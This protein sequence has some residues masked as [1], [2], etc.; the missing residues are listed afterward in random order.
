MI[1]YKDS[2]NSSQLWRQLDFRVIIEPDVIS[3]ALQCL[4]KHTCL[5][6]I[7]AC[8]RETH[9]LTELCDSDTELSTACD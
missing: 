1:A 7:S 6:D 3:A 8:A 9:F 2:I 4:Q 5:F